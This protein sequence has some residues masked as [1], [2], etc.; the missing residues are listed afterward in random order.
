MQQPVQPPSQ[1]VCERARVGRR[2]DLRDQPIDALL[3]RVPLGEEEPLDVRPHDRPHLHHGKHH[4]HG[5]PQ[6]RDRG[7]DAR[8]H[9]RLLREQRNGREGQRADRDQQDRERGRP[10]DQTIDVEQTGARD[11]DVEGNGNH[12][13]SELTGEPEWRERRVHGS[14]QRAE[15]ARCE[16]DVAAEEDPLGLPPPDGSHEPVVAGD[17]DENRG[18]RRAT[19]NAVGANR[20]PR[21]ERRVGPIAQPGDPERCEEPGPARR[22]SVPRPGSLRKLHGRE[23]HERRP[24]KAHDPAH[25]EIAVGL[26]RRGA[27]ELDLR[28]G[29]DEGRRREGRRSR[30]MRSAA[31]DQDPGDRKAEGKRG[32]APDVRFRE[33]SLGIDASLPISLDLE[34]DAPARAGFRVQARVGPPRRRSG[35]VAPARSQQA[36]ADEQLA[37]PR[38]GRVAR[39]VRVRFRSTGACDEDGSA[40]RTTAQRLAQEERG[41]DTE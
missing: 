36:I 21:R 26:Q 20:D 8:A 24:Q 7:V 15:Q 16:S 28:D 41:C 3:K 18:D 34:I 32:V 2:V 37:R 6:L 9:R 11:R 10:A 33:Q 5:E 4:D 39:D 29:P 19:Q 1:Y 14:E 13:E 12:E 30:R 35:E 27:L 25:Q 17:Q 22:L 38:A 23:D 31:H 40:P